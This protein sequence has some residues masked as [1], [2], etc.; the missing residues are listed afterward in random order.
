MFILNKSNLINIINYYEQ[1]YNENYNNNRYNEYYEYID[2]FDNI[3]YYEYIH[4]NLSKSSVA[5]SLIKNYNIDIYYACSIVSIL[6]I[7]ST[8]IINRLNKNIKK[9]SNIYLLP[10]L[11][12]NPINNNYLYNTNNQIKLN[13][14]NL[15]N[16][17]K[18]KNMWN[19]PSY[20]LLP[21]DHTYI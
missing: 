6:W 9:I 2:I 17:F 11:S 5:I 13:K 14:L 20:T 1:F 19:I 16:K 12:T 18:F 4:N 3:C 15:L 8:N 7:S 10:C 21:I